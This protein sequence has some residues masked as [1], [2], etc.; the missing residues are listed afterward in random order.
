M[1]TRF[2]KDWLRELALRALTFKYGLEDMTW[3]ALAEVDDILS[4]VPEGE[5]TG[6]CINNLAG[7][8]T[9]CGK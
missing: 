4:E 3:H 6:L 9:S 8:C 7:E 1:A 5:N 2:Q